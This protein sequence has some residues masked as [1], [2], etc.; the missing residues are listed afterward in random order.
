MSN[1]K[2]Y[3]VNAS[4]RSIDCQLKPSAGTIADTSSQMVPSSQF[5]FN[6]LPVTYKQMHLTAQHSHFNMN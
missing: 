4:S 2:S 1:G 3:Q 6:N 5:E